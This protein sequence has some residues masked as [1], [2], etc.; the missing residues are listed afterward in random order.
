M[1]FGQGSQWEIGLI[2][3]NRALE[4]EKFG[5]VQGTVVVASIS[6]CTSSPQN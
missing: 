3:A 1:E 6:E 2:V 4:V 5:S